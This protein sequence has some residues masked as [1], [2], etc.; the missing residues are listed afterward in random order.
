M[1]RRRGQSAHWRYSLR[2]RKRDKTDLTESPVADSEYNNVNVER[3]A[4][5]LNDNTVPKEQGGRMSGGV[6]VLKDSKT[7]IAMQPADFVTENDF[8]ALLAEFPALLSGEQMDLRAPRRWLLVK[9]EQSVPSQE[10]GGARWSI[11]HLFLDQDG[12]PTLV[13][14]KRRT[15]S[16]IRRE[17]IGQMLDY[18]ANGVAYWP[19]EELQSNFEMTCA[20]R[21]VPVDSAEEIRR[22]LGPEGDAEMFWQLV[23]TNLQAGRIRMV[24]VSDEIPSELRRVVEFLNTQMDPAEVLAVEIRQF[25]GE[26]LKALVP[27]VFGQTEEAQQRKSP[28]PEKRRW[29]EG[30]IYED[31][32]SRVGENFVGIGRKIADWMKRKADRV[33]FGTG[34]RDGSMCV[35][36]ERNGARFFPFQFSSNGRLA[37]NFGYIL[38]PPFDDE[39]KRRDFLKRINDGA[40]LKI[41]D[42]AIDRYPS[43]LL[44]EI[45]DDHRLSGFLGAM[46][47]F[48][49][50]IPTKA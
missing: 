26:G 23:K 21:P 22:L 31:M 16:R 8:Q 4:T 50:Q 38:K 24:F 29:T 13:E 15:D 1:L 3:P 11:D 6:F 5:I 39:V 47:W 28:G 10:G 45:A 2:V 12:V 42:A 25:Q 14:L 41:P 46:D 9:R 44:T 48:T 17:V 19:V 30:L 43:F 35:E 27:V 20:N 7:L 40:G 37:I 49:S 34:V 32:E 18:A 36:F 33:F